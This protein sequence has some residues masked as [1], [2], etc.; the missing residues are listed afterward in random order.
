MRSPSRLV[1]AAVLGACASSATPA[2]N[3]G[4]GTAAFAAQA[5]AARA[6]A[7]AVV[8]AD[9]ARTDSVARRGYLEGVMAVMT[10]DVTYLRGGQPMAFGQ[11]SVHTMLAAALPARGTV[12]RWQPVRVGVSRDGLAAYTVGIA[13]SSVAGDSGRA[14][15]R[16][17]RYIAYWRREADGAWRV[18]AY[19][20]VGPPPA[21]APPLANPGRPRPLTEMPRRDS[22]AHVFMATDSAFSAL[23]VRDGLAAAF[24]TYAASD[25]MTLT[26]SLFSVGPAAIRAQFAG[27]DGG[28]L[29]WHAV[30]GDAANSGDL[31]FT[32]GEYTFASPSGGA[33]HGKYLTV[34][35]AQPSGVW[36]FVADGGNPTSIP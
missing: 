6:R 16:L 1:L 30:A 7:D 5:A 25:A 9:A 29:S 19:A 15:L 21:T 32:V 13:A 28:V 24:G 10:P 23:A 2:P 33:R 12:F 22:L 36:R 14:T 8:A 17:D 34:W 26:G 18:A 20:E 35:A 27:P 3:A 11:L 31:G 4:P